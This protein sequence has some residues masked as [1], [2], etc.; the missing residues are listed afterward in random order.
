MGWRPACSCSF[1]SFW[2]IFFFIFFCTRCVKFTRSVRSGHVLLSVLLW[3]NVS[4]NVLWCVHTWQPRWYAWSHSH[5]WNIKGAFLPSLQP[6][7]AA[8]LEAAWCQRK[9]SVYHTVFYI[10][11]SPYMDIF[12]KDDAAMNTN[13]TVPFPLKP[14][15][16]CLH[17]CAKKGALSL[18]SA[19]ILHRFIE[20][21]KVIAP[22]GKHYCNKFRAQRQA[23]SLAIR[24]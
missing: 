22:F 24:Y 1:P 10:R 11:I 9:I 20:L 23:N 4:Q 21:A 19:I 15:A 13:C 18:F 17:V 3:A 14:E 2:S 7:L 16:R 6:G 12:F 5:S 8:R